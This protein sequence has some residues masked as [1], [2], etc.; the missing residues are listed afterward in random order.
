MNLKKIVNKFGPRRIN[1]KL[2]ISFLFLNFNNPPMNWWLIH[3]YF[4]YFLYN[5]FV[6]SSFSYSQIF[7]KNNTKIYKQKLPTLI[8]FDSICR[9]YL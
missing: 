8:C 1:L 2:I 3:H 7:F 4:Y 6:F 5:F 9:I